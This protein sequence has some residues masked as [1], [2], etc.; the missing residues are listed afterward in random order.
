[1]ASTDA[2][3]RAAGLDG[4]RGVAALCVF[5]VHIWIYT[6]PSRPPRDDFWSYLTF[7]LRLCVVFFFVLSGFLLFRDFA[8]AV[9]RR[10]GPADA[11]GYGIRRVAR[12]VP[13]YYV[14]LLGAVALL[15]GGT[16]E[17]FRAIASEEL[18]LFALFSQNYSPETLLR[19]NP[20]LWTLALEVAFY[21]ALPFIGMLAYR[22]GGVRRTSL[23]LAAL[24]ACGLVYNTL[25]HYGEWG[26]VAAYALPSYL[27][28]FALGMMLSLGLESSLARKG[29]RPELG[30]A[31]TLALLV[32]GFGLV[33]IDGYWHASTLEPALDAGI[34]IFQDL[35]AGFGFAAVISAAA[36]GR[37]P[38]V[39]WTR[40]RPFVYVGV[41]S[42]GFYLWH[43]PLIL[44]IKRLG[45]LPANFF[46]AVAVA[47]PIALAVA[48]ASWHVMEKPAIE[49]AA[50]RTRARREARQ[51]ARAEAQTAP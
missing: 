22:L 5:L 21:I 29:R 42:Y 43:V 47:L 30:P 45:L 16:T 38:A 12:I 44:F 2:T 13:A 41:V 19:F 18:G 49:W 34:G 15:W 24:I 40:F 46:A 9:V 7:E 39:E 25:V 23:L 4:L 14:A 10:S 35:P 17:G 48:A 51:A 28:Y 37:G 6:Q 1:M 36:F 31:A 11:P 26:S 8:R 33:A 27:P 3:R 32:G 20:V 50:R